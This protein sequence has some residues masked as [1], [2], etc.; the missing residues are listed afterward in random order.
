M[1]CG[2]GL[3]TSFLWLH[4]LLVTTLDTPVGF[5]CYRSLQVEKGEGL[6]PMLGRAVFGFAS[7][8]ITSKSGGEE[9]PFVARFSSLPQAEGR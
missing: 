4:A 9:Y 6:F 8:F 7:L 2:W 3:F 5:H 1:V